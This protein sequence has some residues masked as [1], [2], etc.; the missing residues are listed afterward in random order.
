MGLGETYLSGGATPT[1]AKPFTGNLLTSD[2]RR[3]ERTAKLISD[4]HELSIGGPTAAWLF[5]ACRAMDQVNDPDFHSEIT[6]PVL[7]VCA[8][9]DKVVSNLATEDLG[10][11]LRSGS[12][13]TIAGAKHEIL[14]ERDIYREQLLAAFNSFIPGTQMAMAG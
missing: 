11:R 9:N 8:G 12:S 14:Q 3:Y 13:I 7:M 5:A 1:G 4:N 6:I 10:M 2:T